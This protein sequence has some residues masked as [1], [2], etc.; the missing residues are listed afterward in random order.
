MNEISKVNETQERDN[1]IKAT[2][3]DKLIAGSKWIK[4]SYPRSKGLYLV[5]KKVGD[6]EVAYS[7]AT[8]NLRYA[9]ISKAE[10]LRDYDYLTQSDIEAM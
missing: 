8:T 7:D 2:F 4:K 6:N 3:D 1:I 5:V 10:L 9:Y